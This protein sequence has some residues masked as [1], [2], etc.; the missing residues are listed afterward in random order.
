MTDIMVVSLEHE[1]ESDY[2]TEFQQHKRVKQNLFYTTGGAQSFYTYRGADI[3]QIK[4]QDEYAFFARQDFW[5]PDQTLAFI[6]LGCGS[7]GPEQPLLHHAHAQGYQ[8]A[9]FGVDSSHAMLEL[10]QETLSQEHFA[11][12][13][14]QADFSTDACRQALRALVEHFDTRIIAMLGGTFGNFEQ[15]VIV[16]I[17]QHTVQPGDYFYLDI[18]PR[19]DSETQDRQLRRRL[20]Q[21]PQNLSAFFANLLEKLCIPADA[22]EVYAEEAKETVVDAWH[23]AFFF[24]ATRPLTFACSGSQMTL[25]PGET[26]ELFNVRAYNPA[27][28]KT[29]LGE[30]GFV[31]VD[32]YIPDVGELSHLWQRFLFRK[33]GGKILLS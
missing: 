7:A 14:I 8:M 6:S 27:A 4:W 1:L 3:E 29:F 15:S 5:Q 33:A 10:A 28:L 24:K 23:Y 19:Y 26:I 16:S 9:Y 22:G 32:E 30:Y 13:F 17:L 2:L 18:V 31:F 20:A 11:R 25:V 12:H 21:L